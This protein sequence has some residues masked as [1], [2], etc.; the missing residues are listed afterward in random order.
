M[1]SLLEGDVVLHAFFKKEWILKKRKLAMQCTRPVGRGH[2]LKEMFVLKH[3]LRG[4]LS[5]G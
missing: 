5:T 4:S 1:F 2:F 3:F